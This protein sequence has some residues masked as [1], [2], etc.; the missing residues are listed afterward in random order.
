MKGSKAIKAT[1]CICRDKGMSRMDRG[2][3]MKVDT[4]MCRDRCMGRESMDDKY[5]SK[6]NSLSKSNKD[7]YMWISSNQV[8]HSR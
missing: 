4:K 7:K 5:L 3:S 8:Q 2:I 1:I 6:C